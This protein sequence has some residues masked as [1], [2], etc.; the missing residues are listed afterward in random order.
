MAHMLGD[1]NAFRD[2]RDEL[3]K[4]NLLESKPVI[5]RISGWSRVW[6]NDQCTYAPVR[7][8]ETPS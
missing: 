8:A 7:S 4:E 1:I 5:Y 2:V 6:S 3:L